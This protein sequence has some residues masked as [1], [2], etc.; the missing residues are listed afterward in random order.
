MKPGA[1]KLKYKETEYISDYDE[2]VPKLEGIIKRA[3][4]RNPLIFKSGNETHFFPVHIVERSIITL[5]RKD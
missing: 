5:I 2:D 3:I 1:I 4:D